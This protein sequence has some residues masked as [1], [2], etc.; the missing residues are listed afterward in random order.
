M[1]TN[2]MGGYFPSGRQRSREALL[3]SEKQGKKKKKMRGEAPWVPY[4]AAVFADVSFLRLSFLLHLG[5]KR[6]PVTL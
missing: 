1:G 3:Q 2:K 5:Y 6:H 4:R